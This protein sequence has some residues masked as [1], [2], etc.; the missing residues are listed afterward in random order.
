MK[1]QYK[2]RN[3]IRLI[4]EMGILMDAST[5]WT[6]DIAK[7]DDVLFLLTYPDGTFIVSDTEA[8]SVAGGSAATLVD[9]GIMDGDQLAGAS[10]RAQEIADRCGV[11]MEVV[12]V[13][14]AHARDRMNKQSE[15]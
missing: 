12:Q 1:I 8:V 6:Q 14:I 10:D 11:D 2:P 7:Q 13:W 5:D 4:T 3:G 15:D 9:M